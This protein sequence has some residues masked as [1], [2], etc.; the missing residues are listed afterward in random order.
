MAHT[1]VWNKIV[2]SRRDSA[3]VLFN[4]HAT[5][6]CWTSRATLHPVPRNVRHDS[7]AESERE[8]RSLE[9][10]GPDL[11]VA[12]KELNVL[13][14]DNNEIEDIPKKYGVANLHRFSVSGNKIHAVPEA[15]YSNYRTLHLDLDNNRISYISPAI[16]K[17]TLLRTIRVANNSIDTVPK[18]LF[19]NVRVN[20]I[21]SG[22]RIVTL[23]DIQGATSVRFFG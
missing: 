11:F 1:W 16:G 12:L 7:V 8:G 20:I 9:N 14:V 3:T 18:E 15:V 21:L 4:L 6:W 17:A 10:T 13:C 5:A 22:N 23:P 19:T 2:R